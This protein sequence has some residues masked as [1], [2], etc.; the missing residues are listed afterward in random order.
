M[1]LLL[2]DDV[3]LATTFFGTIQ[4]SHDSIPLFVL[5]I[6]VVSEILRMNHQDWASDFILTTKDLISEGIETWVKSEQ[7]LGLVSLS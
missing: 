7:G 6:R 2:H 4:D 3:L 1:S 5:G